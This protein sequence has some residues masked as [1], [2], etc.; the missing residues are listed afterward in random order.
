MRAGTSTILLQRCRV[1]TAGV[2]CVRTDVRGARSVVGSTGLAVPA[3]DPA[4]LAAAIVDL[5]DRGPVARA[6]L[7]PAAREGIAS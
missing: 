1:S 7:G 6:V 5:I 2:P 3:R 4:A